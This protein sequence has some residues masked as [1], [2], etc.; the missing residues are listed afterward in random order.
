MSATPSAGVP[1]AQ[2]LR[3][4]R[5][6]RGLSIA[7]LAA[8]AEVSPRLISELERGM[9]AHVSFDTATRLL[10]LVGVS[11]TFE[12]LVAPADETARTRAERRRQLWTGE[13][14]TLSAQA[15]PAPSP[16]AAARLISVARASRL[17]AGLQVAYDA[18]K[19][20][21]VAKTTK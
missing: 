10:H 4:A 2:A 6:R 12:P 19:S 8:L 11:V 9:R 16:D 21:R 3:T 18:T 14:S 13:Q 15:P 5:K 20:A 17:V 7:Q 1:L